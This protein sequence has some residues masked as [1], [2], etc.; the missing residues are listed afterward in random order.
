MVLLRRVLLVVAVLAAGV[1]VAWLVVPRFITPEE[2]E[3][4]REPPE[5]EPIT[6]LAEVGV[7]REVLLLEAEVRPRIELSIDPWEPVGASRGVVTFLPEPGTEVVSGDPVV[8]LS[9]RPLIFVTGMSN[10]YRDLHRGLTGSDVQ[11]LQ[12][13]L[14][15]FGYLDNPDEVDGVFGASTEEAVRGWYE[16]MGFVPAPPPEQVSTTSVLEAQNGVDQA[17]QT[18]RSARASGDQTAV[19]TARRSL[20]IAEAQLAALQSSPTLVVPANE[21]L[22]L[23]FESVVVDS[24]YEEGDLVDPERSLLELRTTEAIVVASVTLAQTNRLAKGQSIVVMVGGRE[25]ESTVGEIIIAEP[26]SSPEAFVRIDAEVRDLQ[27]GTPASVEVELDATTGDVVSV[28]VSAVRAD[29]DGE[30][31]VTIVIGDSQ[32][33]VDVE[34]G[35]T[36]GG[37]T[38][39]VS[40]LGGG[41]QVVVG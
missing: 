40:G 3:A 19:S 9:G 20:A 39:I 21:V 34:V 11:A 24:S 18:L 33:R 35:V 10:L 8:G 36:I 32:T 15:E 30:S 25:V 16:G 7:L 31:Y 2:A 29:A 22:G 4:V 12:M 23:P 38:E 41:E 6:A 14:L 27:P 37:R 5:P 17:R 28:P 1:A 13:T 26:G